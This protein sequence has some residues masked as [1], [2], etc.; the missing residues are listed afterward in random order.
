M[1]PGALGVSAV[2]ISGFDFANP[3]ALA[4]VDVSVS[5]TTASFAIYA[6]TEEWI[7]RST[8]T[9]ANQPFFGT[10]MRPLR[11]DRSIIANGRFSEL[12]SGYGEIE[13]DNSEGQY[14]E[15]IKRTG[16][17]GANLTVKVRKHGRP[18]EEAI[19]LFSGLAESWTVAEQNVIVRILDSSFRLNVPAQPDIYAGTGGLEGG[20]DLAGK[21]KIRTFG[22][23]SNIT[24]AAL[25]PQELV[26]QVND[27]AVQDI[28]AVYDR[29]AALTIDTTPDY[30]NSTLLRAATI[31]AGKYATCLAEGLFRL[32]SAPDGLV[33]CD[34]EGDVLDG[35]YVETSADIVSRLLA[36]ATDIVVPDDLVTSTFDAVNTA[37]PATIGFHLAV[38]SNMTVRDAVSA[39]MGAIGGW[40]GFRRSGKFEVAIFAAPSGTP[41]ATYDEKDVID[42]RREQLPDG[43]D[44]PPW[45][46]R[47][48]WGRNWTVQTTDIA[49]GVTAARIAFLKDAVRL[50]EA[51]D[52]VILTD[53]PRAQDPAPVEAEFAQQSDAQD[54]ADRQLALYR[55]ARSLYRVTVKVAPFFHEIGQVISLTYPRWDLVDGRLLTIVA[56]VQDADENSVEIV[57]FG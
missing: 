18:Y 11:V 12:S 25:I 27:G 14:D 57:A 10:L 31:G 44:P 7:T 39:I 21:R 32:A 30:P 36:T 56:L 49:G 2:P 29:A 47:V 53:H 40:A 16:V 55:V 20:D 37:Q 54:E 48:A 9:P 50:A 13:L 41:T 52:T 42:I 19:V 28:P 6:A 15:Q 38:D 35:D 8:D 22:E 33:T 23:C 26:Y 46:W 45:R 3:R 51:S 1:I 4:W 34:V 43:I 24:P 17:D 5:I